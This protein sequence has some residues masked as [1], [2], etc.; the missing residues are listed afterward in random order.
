MQKTIIEQI[1]KTIQ[2]ILHFVFRSR[3]KQIQNLK[4][5]VF[6]YTPDIAIGKSN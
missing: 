1:Q 4:S 6:C 5:V 2:K 3:T